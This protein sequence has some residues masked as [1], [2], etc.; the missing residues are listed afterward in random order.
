MLND[1]NPMKV[2]GR[3]EGEYSWLSNFYASPILIVIPNEI[4]CPHEMVAPTVEHYFQARKCIKYSDAY[5]I[6]TLDTPG[7][8]KREG[9]KVQMFSNW[10]D[11]KYGIMVE[12]LRLKFKIPELRAKLLATGDSLLLEGNNWHDNLWGSCSCSK[13]ASIRGKNLLGTALM[14]VRDEIRKGYI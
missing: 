13:C 14:Q 3:F 12:G 1:I 8:A 2:I 6:L 5:N 4:G 9:R 7:K 11:I 10:D